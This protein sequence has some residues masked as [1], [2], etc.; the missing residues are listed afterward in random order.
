MNKFEHISILGHQCQYWWGL[1]SKVQCL[2][3]GGPVQWSTMSGWGGA[4]GSCTMES[5]FHRSG[6]V[7]WGSMYGGG[8]SDTN[9]S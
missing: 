9:A 2:R 4:W 3:V 1:Y 8:C 5:H 6:P 7:L